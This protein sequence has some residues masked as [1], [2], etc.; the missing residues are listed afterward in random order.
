MGKGTVIALR[1]PEGTKDALTT[2][3]RNGAR[4]LLRQAVEVELKEFLQK[5]EEL[6]LADRRQRI[7]RNGYLPSREV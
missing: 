1:G 3:F 4:E 5:H 6:R 7:D 2:L